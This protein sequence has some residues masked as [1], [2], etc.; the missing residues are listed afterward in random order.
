MISRQYYHNTEN[1]K[2]YHVDICLGDTEECKKSI[3]D[4]VDKFN[5]EDILYVFINDNNAIEVSN[6]VDEFVSKIKNFI[7]LYSN[8]DDIHSA[9]SVVDH[10]NTTRFNSHL[11]LIGQNKKTKNSKQLVFNI[12]KQYIR[13]EKLK[14]ILNVKKKY[15]Q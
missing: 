7:A 2:K 11:W 9:I 4:F 6:Y 8:I 13:E 10:N 5:G 14:R 15:N 1:N 3:D 12:T